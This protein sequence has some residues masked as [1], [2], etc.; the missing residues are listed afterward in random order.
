MNEKI[1]PSPEDKIIGIEY[2]LKSLTV[3]LIQEDK[4]STVLL[5]AFLNGAHAKLNKPGEE[6]IAACI[7]RFHRDVDT[8]I[9][10][11]EDAFRKADEVIRARKAAQ[12]R[13][14]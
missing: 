12:K 11:K 14:E 10:A 4:V 6:G 9:E 1:T 13:H 2:A 7:S 3:A 8:I 5:K